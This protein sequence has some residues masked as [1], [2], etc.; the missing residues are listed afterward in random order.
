MAGG[1]GFS[2]VIITLISIRHIKIVLRSIS[3]LK[4]RMAG[5]FGFSWVII[6]LISIRHIKIVLRL[7]VDSVGQKTKHG[8]F[9]LTSQLPLQLFIFVEPEKDSRRQ[10]QSR[11]V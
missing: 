3:K 2:W 8:Q 7:K 10:V 1:F 11:H 4:I 6:T 5:G 9:F